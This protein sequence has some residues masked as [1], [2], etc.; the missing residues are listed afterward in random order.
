MT[1]FK[2]TDIRAGRRNADGSASVIIHGLN[3]N[4][5]VSTAATD[6][7]RV[8]LML[9]VFAM[10]RDCYF[11]DAHVFQTT[12]EPWTTNPSPIGQGR[13]D[14]WEFRIPEMSGQMPELFLRLV[15]D[16]QKTQSS[17]STASGW[18]HIQIN[19]GQIPLLLALLNSRYCYYQPTGL[20]NT[21]FV[22][23]LGW[24]GLP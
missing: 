21:D 4:V 6:P 2:I 12:L 22:A 8:G 11:D 5:Q 16:A 19:E 13:V 17:G 14:S 3:Q 20:R 23:D 15:S 1:A 9:T 7:A 10:G 18:A 24:A